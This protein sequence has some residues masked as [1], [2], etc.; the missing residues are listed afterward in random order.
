MLDVK[1]DGGLIIGL[2]VHACWAAELVWRTWLVPVGENNLQLDSARVK[3][4]N[5]ANR[6]HAEEAYPIFV[7]V[8]DAVKC[9]PA[10][11][12]RVYALTASYNL[13]HMA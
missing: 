2:T 8:C 4:C 5:L 10:A 1:A 9:K 3:V 13:T 12:L 7:R 11:I 6:Q